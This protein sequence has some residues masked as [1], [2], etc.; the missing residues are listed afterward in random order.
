MNKAV[1]K[2][3]I[4]DGMILWSPGKKCQRKNHGLTLDLICAI[5]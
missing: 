1:G 5:S 2:R 3:S 4:V